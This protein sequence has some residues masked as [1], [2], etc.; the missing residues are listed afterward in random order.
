MIGYLNSAKVFLSY[1]IYNKLKVFLTR[2]EV[3]TEN[4]ALKLE[5]IEQSMKESI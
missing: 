2:L 3:N 1:K 5:E 4:L